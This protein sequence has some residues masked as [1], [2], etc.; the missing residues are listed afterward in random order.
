[1]GVTTWLSPMTGVDAVE[2]E[3]RELI[4]RR[5]IDPFTDRGAVRRL[6]DEVVEDYDER[7]LTSTVPP[8]QDAR[9]APKSSTT[10]SPG[11]GC[12]S[13]TSTTPG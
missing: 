6:V 7:T 10:R 3:V 4:R 5:G 1:M 12:C 13:G 11:L 2:L 8:L 9:H